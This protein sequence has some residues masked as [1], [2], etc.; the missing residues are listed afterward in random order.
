MVYRICLARFPSFYHLSGVCT[1]IIGGFLED[2][3]PFMKMS[4]GI[5]KEV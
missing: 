1:L 4:R 3:K 2:V 5:R